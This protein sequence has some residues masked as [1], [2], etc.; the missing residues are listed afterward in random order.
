VTV[1]RTFL[2]A[3]LT[4]AI[5]AGP[6]AGIA[7]ADAPQRSAWW[8][9]I[10]GPGLA[11]PQPTTADGDLHVAQGPGEP[12]AFAALMYAGSDA[13]SVRLVLTLREGREVGTPLVV[14][15][16]TTAV[17]WEAGGNQPAEA[18]PAYDCA[19]PAQGA[20]S[21]DG[22][23]MSFALDERQ[24]IT[25]GTWSVAL[26]PQPGS[27]AP[28]S[29]DFA[30][31]DQNV[32]IPAE[33]PRQDAPPATD[34]FPDSGASTPPPSFE[35]S[36]GSAPPADPAPVAEAPV[37]QTPEV[38]PAVPVPAATP[39]A[40]SAS[41]GSRHV[42]SGERLLA[43]LTLFAGTALVGH[44]VQQERHAPHLLG[45]RARTLTVPLPDADLRPGPHERPRGIGRFARMRTEPPRRLR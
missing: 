36:F 20:L 44:S 31:P 45:G 34:G 35:S 15:C 22:T 13:P 32:F 2:Q 11:A 10:S 33:R 8:N 43:L 29:L 14:A 19:N 38:T 9:T 39:A 21:E 24:Q 6:A 12:L 41:P 3:V 18:A 42:T 17:D 25:P 16:P 1:L 5:V 23:T 28:F 40:G 30:A 4:A 7:V 26:V 37:V 27:N